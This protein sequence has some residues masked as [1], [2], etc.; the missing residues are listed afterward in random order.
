METAGHPGLFEKETRVFVA[1]G[2]N[3]Q[4]LQPKVSHFV[5]RAIASAHADGRTVRVTRVSGGV[6]IQIVHVDDGTGREH[7]GL[8]V[9]VDGLTVDIPIVDLDQPLLVAVGHCGPSL[10]LPGEVVGV[11]VD[12]KEMDGYGQGEL[13]V[14][15]K[16]VYARR[17]VEG[18]I[19]LKLEEH[20]VLGC[21]GRAEVEADAGSNAFWLTRGFQVHVEDEVVTG[22]EMPLSSPWLGDGGRVRFPEEEV[23]VG[24]EGGSSVDVEFHAGDAGLPVGGVLPAKGA[25]AIEEDVCVMDG[26][27][28]TREDLHGADVPGRSKREG[29]DEVAEEVGTACGGCEGSGDGENEVRRAKLPLGGVGGGWRSGGEVARGHAGEDPA[30]DGVTVCV[31]EA[32]GIG[33]VAEAGGGEPWRHVSGLSDGVDFWGVAASVVEGGKRERPGPVGV[34]AGGAMPVQDGGDIVGVVLGFGLGESRCGEKDEGEK[35]HR[36]TMEQPTG[37]AAGCWMAL[38]SIAAAM[39]SARS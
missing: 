10:H 39:A 29:K 7:D 15:G 14:D 26:C 11:R 31:G 38:W 24:V 30:V 13:V 16:C 8:T 20:G 36:G 34:V 12:A 3:G 27:G 6:V 35:L 22:V 23:A 28:G 9:S 33:E 19:M 17:D 37:R 1:G 25:G 18:C 4:D 21:G 32:P 2:G 5:F